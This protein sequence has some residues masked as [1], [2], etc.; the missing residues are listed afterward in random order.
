MFSISFFLS[1][2]SVVF[3]RLVLVCL[4]WSWSHTD[5]TAF[6]SVAGQAEAFVRVCA[7]HTGSSVGTRVG[8]AHLYLCKKGGWVTLLYQRGWGGGGYPARWG[9]V[10]DGLSHFGTDRLVNNTEAAATSVAN[11]KTY[12]TL[13]RIT[14]G[15]TKWWR[16]LLKYT[17]QNSKR[18]AKNCNVCTAVTFCLNLW[19][20]AAED[21]YL[22]SS[23]MRATIWPQIAHMW[24]RG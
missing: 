5:L 12:Y 10:I 21:Q 22:F 7:L 14:W 23:R 1:L 17:K 6:P 20:V 9:G 13:N 24:P 16:Y 19:L 11:L 4:S 15:L 2:S 18:T 3:E 8:I